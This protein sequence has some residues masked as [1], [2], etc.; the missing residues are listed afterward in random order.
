MIAEGRHAEAMTPQ[1]LAEARHYRRLRLAVAVSDIILD[2]ACL[3]AAAFWLAKPIDLWLVQWGWLSRFATLRLA[4][5]L[6][7]VAGLHF[8]VSL[9]LDFYAGY[10]LEHRFHLSTLSLPDWLWRLAK[11]A[12]LE[13]V[14]GL[15]A[16][17]GLYWIAWT[18]GAWWWLVAA[19]AFFLVS[20]LFGQLAPV[21]ILPLF[22]TVKRLD[23]PELLQRMRDLARAPA[24]RSK[25]SIA[26]H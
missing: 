13:G 11:Q 7:I 22:Y 17:L 10:V 26:W 3:A 25:G 9:P 4:A 21:L 2:L 20:V 1:E 14:L 6:L 12:L 16:F 8:A 15:A 19:A 5:L 24:C 18:T 23:D